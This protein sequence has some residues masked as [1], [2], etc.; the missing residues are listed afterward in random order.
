M[1]DRLRQLLEFLEPYI[2]HWGQCHV[3]ARREQGSEKSTEALLDL[4][5][6]E[7]T[8]EE[9]DRE[10]CMVMSGSYKREGVKESPLELKVFYKILE[11][12]LKNCP[13]YSLMVSEYSELDDQHIARLDFPLQNIVVDGKSKIIRLLF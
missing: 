7:M 11:T 13:D 12:Y 5:I 3:V 6:I 2:E 8:A 9:S 10:I 4:P 1:S